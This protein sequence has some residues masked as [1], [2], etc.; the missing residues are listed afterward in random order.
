MLATELIEILQDAIEMHGEDLEVKLAEQPSWPFQ[1]DIEGAVVCDKSVEEYI[2]EV[3]ME[4]GRDE[5]E[6]KIFQRIMKPPED[7][8]IFLV[9]GHQECY[10]PS[11]VKPYIQEYL[12]AYDWR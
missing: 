12:Q 2:D 3:R 9:E 11:Y 4:Y 7:P 6:D 1:Y 10:L 5:A 8:I